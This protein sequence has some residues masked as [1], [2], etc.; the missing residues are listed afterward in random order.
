VPFRYPVLGVGDGS[1]AFLSVGFLIL[2]EVDSGFFLKE[3]EGQ[4]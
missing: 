2:R 1:Q 3:P 4:K